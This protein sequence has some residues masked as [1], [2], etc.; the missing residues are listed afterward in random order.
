MTTY[1][2]KELKLHNKCNN[3]VLNKTKPKRE[4]EGQRWGWTLALTCELCLRLEYIS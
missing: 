2:N 1:L 4:T 3:Q